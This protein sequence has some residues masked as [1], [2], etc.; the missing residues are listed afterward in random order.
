MFQLRT[1]ITQNCM[2]LYTLNNNDYISQ[3]VFNFQ[4]LFMENINCMT[5]YYKMVNYFFVLLQNLSTFKIQ[6]QTKIL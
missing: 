1:V 6:I 4:F 3:L 5:Y 2:L